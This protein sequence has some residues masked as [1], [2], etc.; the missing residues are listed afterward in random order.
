MDNIST[1]NSQISN[2]DISAIEKCFSL[3]LIPMI[4]G[5]TVFDTLKGGTIL[6]TED[7]FLHLCRLMKEP[8]RILLAGLEEG[9]WSDFPKREKLIDVF[10]SD[11][12]ETDEFIQ[13]SV[14]TDVTGGMSEKVRLMKNIIESG[15]A[16]SAVIFS[17]E[18]E[19]NTENALTGKNVG[20]LIRKQE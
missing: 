15:N 6:S 10:F 3:H 14:F 20:T 19:G 11:Q 5:D 2:W 17:G 8:P 18:T 9:V 12:N 4:F 1:N 13:G 16:H 7:I